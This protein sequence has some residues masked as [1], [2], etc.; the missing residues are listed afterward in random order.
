MRRS[1]QERLLVFC[2]KASALRDCQLLL[3]FQ[4]IVGVS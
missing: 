4:F 2:R 3:R 1:I